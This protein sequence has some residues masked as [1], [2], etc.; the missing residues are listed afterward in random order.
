MAESVVLVAEKREGFGSHKAVKLRRQGL[1]PAVLYGHKQ[2]TLAVSVNHDELFSAVK[3]GARVLDLKSDSGVETALIKAIQ[4]DHLG[5]DILHADF[6]RVSKDERITV[7]VRI[8]LRGIAPGA[9]AGGV[10]DQPLHTV[11]L[12]CLAISIPESIRVNIGELQLGQAIHVRDLKAPEGVKIV[13]DP[14][15]IVVHVTSPQAEAEAAPAEGAVEPEVIGRA[16]AEEEEA[17]EK[18]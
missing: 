1:I 8:E 17:E 10:L 12:E 18:K 16:K 9:T 11:E 15:A 2:D 6:E 7:S 3:H 4:W 5:K 13:G 14:D